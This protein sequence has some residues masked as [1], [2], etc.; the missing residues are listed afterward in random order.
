MSGADWF[1][2]LDHGILKRHS[3]LAELGIAVGPPKEVLS[4]L[5]L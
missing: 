2:T 1:V 3:E 4:S 5:Q